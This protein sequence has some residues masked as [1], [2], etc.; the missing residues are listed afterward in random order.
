MEILKDKNAYMTY[1]PLNKSFICFMQLWSVMKHFILAFISFQL[2]LTRPKSPNLTRR[3]SSGDA[4]RLSRDEKAKTCC[5]T[6]RHSLGI[7]RERSTT[8]N[9]VKS[10]GQ[11]GGQSSNGAG[12]VKDRAKQATKAAP[13]KITEQSNANITVES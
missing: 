11:V 6:H 8:A 2:P 7:H 1:T 12:K 13:S 3:K 5:Q 4:V 10:K 9:E